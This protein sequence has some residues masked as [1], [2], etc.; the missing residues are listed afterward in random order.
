MAPSSPSETLLLQGTT[1]RGRITGDGDVR[2]YGTLQGEAVLRGTLTV[3]E[4]GTVQGGTIEAFNASIAGELSGEVQIA[5]NLVVLPSGRLQGRVRAGALQ[6][7]EGATLSCELDCDFELP[8]ELR[9][10]VPQ[11]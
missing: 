1:L 6:I 10:N 2:I 7:H 5:Q 9:D 3:S 8:E 11:R 4:G